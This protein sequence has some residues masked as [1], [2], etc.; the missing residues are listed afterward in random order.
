MMPLEQ[1]S[2]NGRVHG[3][4]ALVTG[5]AKGIGAASARLLAA[6]GA[7]VL[8]SDLD[9][10]AGQALAAEIGPTTAF[11]RHD[12]SNE[13]QWRQ[14]IEHVRKR[15]GR[16]DIL[17]NNAGILIAGSIEETSLADWH[18]VMRVN[19]DSVFLGCRE[20]IALMKDSGGSIINLS[21]IAALAGR[22]D[23]LAYSASKGAVAA[24]SRSVAVM[25][26]RRKYRIRCNTLH[27]DGVLT[28][29]TR[30]GFPEGIDPNRLTI[31]S[32]PMN[33][34]CRPEDVAA[35]V[36]FLASDEARAINGVELRVD[37]GQMVMSI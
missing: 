21:S 30:G 13:D 23:Y 16:L 35:S 12:V 31:D 34:M 5:G 6:E 11:I 37:S 14:V 1:T 25:C 17:V 15:Y 27:P 4:V 36:L 19:A 26:R 24:L 10:E 33:R 20:G 28:D 18:K 32:D 29:M 22:D 2:K 3:K 9:V 7:Q 8:I